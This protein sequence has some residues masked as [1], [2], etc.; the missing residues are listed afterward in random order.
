MCKCPKTE[1]LWKATK[2]EVHRL[3]LGERTRQIL[4][5]HPVHSIVVPQIH[6]SRT[7]FVLSPWMILQPC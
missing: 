1:G 6:P 4:S 2:V 5:P 7:P 3:H